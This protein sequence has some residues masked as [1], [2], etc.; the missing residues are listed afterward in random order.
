MSL[1]REAVGITAI[2]LAA[3]LSLVLFAVLDGR[4]PNDHD[5]YYTEGSLEHILEL[6]QA[7]TMGERGSILLDHFLT[8]GPHPDYPDQRGFYP[9]LGQTVLIAVLDTFGSSRLNYRL[10]NLP[11]LILLVLGTWLLGRRLGGPRVGLAAALLVLVLPVLLSHGRKFIPH[12]FGAALAPWAWLFLVVALQRGGT[13]GWMA[14]LA[15]GVVQGL[16]A[17]CHPS[18]YPDIALSTGLVLVLAFWIMAVRRDRESVW[19]L[20]RVALAGGIVGLFTSYLFGWTE[21]WLAE[22]S[23]SVRSYIQARGH[24][25]GQP[26]AETVAL[27]PAAAEQMVVEW[28][29]MHL[30]PSGMLLLGAGLA[31]A[32]PRFLRSSPEARVLGRLLVLGVCLQVPLALSTVARGTFTSDWVV[33]LPA[34]CVLAAW[35]VLE[36]VQHLD[37][38]ARSWLAVL[39]LHGVF[40]L[41]APFVLMAVGPSPV[42]EPGWY[43]SGTAGLFSRSSTGGLWNTHHIPLRD[44]FVGDRLA[45]T[46]ATGNYN[47]LRVVELTRRNADT[48]SPCLV[49]LGEEGAWMWGPPATA[50]MVTRK[51]F[52]WPLLSQ[53]VSWMQP[54][55]YPDQRLWTESVRPAPR[56]SDRVS[57]WMRGDDARFLVVVRLWVDLSEERREAW[58]SCQPSRPTDELVDAARE[59][60]SGLMK[61]PRLIADLWDFGGELYGLTDEVGREPSYLSRALVFDPALP[62]AVPAAGLEGRPG[63]AV[64][65]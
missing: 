22:P 37:R 30:F 55:L 51:W 29:Q 13:R 9:R 58:R 5:P 31:C 56:A 23:Y 48:E 18:I 19:S 11:W 35:G 24:I 45:G 46:L 7:A 61:D 42:E 60:L 32:L 16:R 20:L 41:A 27:F 64:S 10:A 38:F 28:W 15:A 1:K 65:P 25:V 53:G 3:V 21:P 17:Y 33:L 4:W 26:L 43:R 52:V 8:G 57:A 63:P 39:L 44:G 54:R 50:R 40:V 36:G 47:E 49:G 14:A 12:Y 6:E 62:A 59:G 34:L 2:L